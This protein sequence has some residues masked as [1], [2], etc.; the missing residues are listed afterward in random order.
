MYNLILHSFVEG[1]ALI[2]MFVHPPYLARGIAGHECKVG[3]IFGDHR[4]GANHAVLPECVTAYNRRIGTD[5]RTAFDE[6]RFE[7]ILTADGCTRVDDV[8]EDH[9]RAEEHIVLA[10]HAGIDGY[11]IL[12]LA[13]PAQHYVG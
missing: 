8:G 12:H 13:V 3:H 9:G 4:T 2:A 7:L 10:A 6:R 5:G 11:I 1:S